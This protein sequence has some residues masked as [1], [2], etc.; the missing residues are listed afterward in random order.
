[1]RPKTNG[2]TPSETT[3]ITSVQSSWRGSNLAVTARVTKQYGDE[4]DD[5]EAFLGPTAEAEDGHDDEQDRRRSLVVGGA[6]ERDEEHGKDR[7]RHHDE[8]ER[9]AQ[10]EQRRGE[11]LQSHR[12]DPAA[13]T[14]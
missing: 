13:R 11:R 9:A 3:K 5:A 14:E 6:G 4:Q 1:M 7:S 12:G 2:G 8:C 10:H